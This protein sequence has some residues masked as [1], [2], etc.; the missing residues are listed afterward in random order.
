VPPLGKQSGRRCW[1]LQTR[2]ETE[3]GFLDL[4]EQ[5]RD[6]SVATQFRVVVAQLFEDRLAPAV[7]GPE[8][9][10]PRQKLLVNNLGW[11]I[12]H[13]RWISLGEAAV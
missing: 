4:P 10:A 9:F 7:Q 8:L 1:L 12:E 11:A 2:T 5:L 13:A 6:R 3:F